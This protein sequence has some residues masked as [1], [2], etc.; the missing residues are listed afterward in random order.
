MYKVAKFLTRIRKSLLEIGE[1]TYM[2]HQTRY[3]FYFFILLI[4]VCLPIYTY[5]VAP[6]Y[7]VFRT[8]NVALGITAML[9]LLLFLWDKLRLRHT[10]CLLLLATQIEISLGMIACALSNI[11]YQRLLIMSNNVLATMCIMISVCAY[12]YK[13]SVVLSVLS[14]TA[15][16]ACAEITHGPFLSQYLFLN[17]TLLFLASMLGY[18]LFHNVKK[19]QRENKM[20]KDEE[21]KILQTLQINRKELYALV[22]LVSKDRS[23]QETQQLLDSVGEKAK[24]NLLKTAHNHI[25]EEN[26]QLSL[27]KKAFPELSATEQTICRLIL[28]DKT[29]TEICNILYK[30]S[31][32]ITCHRAHIRAKLKLEK[33]DNL[34]EKL[35]ERLQQSLPDEA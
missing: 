3:V 18:L 6:P 2:E 23:E 20:L 7:P 17:I 12:L 13:L 4:S 22:D 8:M 14:L 11:E 9:L 10:F 21:Q 19:L 26:S 35:K 24:E 30:S 25:R 5:D 29:V 32:N 15:Y 16:I 33:E 34:K 31:G 27:I 1:E 28:Q